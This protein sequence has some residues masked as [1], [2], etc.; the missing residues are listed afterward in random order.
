VKYIKNYGCNSNIVSFAKLYQKVRIK[1]SSLGSA[2]LS[3]GTSR[4]CWN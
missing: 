2:V 3:T 1:Y 4:T